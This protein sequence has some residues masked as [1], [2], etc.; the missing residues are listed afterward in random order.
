ME[1]QNLSPLENAAAK[2][3]A[4][5]RALKERAKA[6]LI[7]SRDGAARFEADITRQLDDIFATLSQE[8]S[9]EAKNASAEAGTLRTEIDRIKAQLDAARTLWLKE[10][11]ELE[12]Q[13]DELS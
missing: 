5:L 9:A 10:R 2:S 4:A 3:A 7:A 12:S 6:A 11:A 1:E 13:R 8:T